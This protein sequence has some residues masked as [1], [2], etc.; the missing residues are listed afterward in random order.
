MATCR[1]SETSRAPSRLELGEGH[2]VGVGDGLA[3]AAGLGELG[4]LE[5]PHRPLAGNAGALVVRTH[6][7]RHGY[8]N[9]YHEWPS[10]R[11]RRLSRP[12]QPRRLRPSIV[13]S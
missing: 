7:G 1:A 10:I 12:T 2:A 4:A 3:D 8:V 6:Q 5:A 11:S 13:L 9:N